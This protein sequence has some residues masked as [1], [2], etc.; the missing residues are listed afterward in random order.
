MTIGSPIGNSQVFILDTLLRPVPPGVAGELYIGGVQLAR[1]YVEDPVRTAERFVADPVSG[2]PGARIY[3]TGDQARF[4]P[5]GTI[6]F[7]GRVDNQLKIRGRR[8]APEEI[9]NALT[10]HPCVRRAVVMAQGDRLVGYC[11][12][13]DPALTWLQLRDWLRTRLPEHLVPPTGTILDTLPEL[14]SGKIDRAAIQRIPIEVSAAIV[15]YL[16]PR[17]AMER[18][19]V[20]LWRVVLKVPRIGVDDNFFDMGG[21]SLLLAR[22]Q[23]KLSEQLGFSVSLLDLYAH[24]TVAELATYLNAA[25]DG[26]TE[27]ESM[28]GGGLVAARTRA[29]RGR[30][31]RA[32]RLSQQRQ[33]R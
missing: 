29:E 19:L 8:I 30:D 5:D 28:D 21:H 32:Q 6:E 4:L 10:S 12:S 11:A 13:D 27:S 33:R 20:D 7:L 31:A 24:P 17:Y 14:A 16:E 2:T 25:R 1:G 15:P 23:A 3:R 22:V 18:V 9:E 26:G